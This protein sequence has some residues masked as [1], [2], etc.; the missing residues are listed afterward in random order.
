MN[1]SENYQRLAKLWKN[2]SRTRNAIDSHRSLPVAV[3]RLN[4]DAIIQK[5]LDPIEGKGMTLGQVEF[6]A[7]E[8]RRFLAL[9]VWHPDAELVPNRLIDEF[10]HAH[11]LDTMAYVRDCEAVFGQYLHHYPYM[12]LGSAQAQRELEDAFAVTRALYERYFGR[13]PTEE[14]TAARCKGHAC[15]APSPCACRVPGAC[16]SSNPLATSAIRQ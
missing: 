2:K 4:F 3:S 5:L 1:K 6:A 13:Y 8:Y 14:S 11:I 7:S 15:H 16:K 10:W 12:G 9:R